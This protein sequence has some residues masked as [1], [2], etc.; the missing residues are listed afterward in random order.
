ME[1]TRGDPRQSPHPLGTDFTNEVRAAVA[2]IAPGEVMSYGQIALLA[3]RRGAARAVGQVLSRSQ[4]LPWWRVVAAN[5]RLVPGLEIQHAQRLLEEG[6]V[7]RAAPGPQP[8]LV[9]GRCT[10]ISPGQVAGGSARAPKRR[11]P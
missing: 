6:L 2:A 3:G 4:G 9:S 7:A 11:T 8:W 10:K 5:G 1:R